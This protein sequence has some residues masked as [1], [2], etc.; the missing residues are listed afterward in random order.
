MIDKGIISEN[1][2]RT[3]SQIMNDLGFIKIYDTGQTKWIYNT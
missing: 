1:D 3:E 2:N